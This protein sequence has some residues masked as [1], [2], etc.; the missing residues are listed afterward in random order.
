[1]KRI[2]PHV[3]PRLAAIFAVLVAWGWS[4]PGAAD[5]T[6]QTVTFRSADQDLTG[7]NPTMLTGVLMRPEGNGPFPA[8]VLLHS[9]YG[10]R[11]SDGSEVKRFYFW[12]RYL[13]D[14]GFVTLLVDSYGPRGLQRLCPLPER[15]RPIKTDRERV[16]DAYG[17]LLY[18]Q[19]RKD[20]LARSVGVMG[21]SNGGQ[22]AIWTIGD[23]HSGRPASL[24]E[25]D[26]RAALA[27][28]P[29]GCQQALRA[30]WKTNIPFLMLIGEADDWTG[31]KPCVD[32]TSSAKATGAPVEI[33]LYPGAHH[34]FD[35]PDMP[36]QVVK[37]VVLP[38]GHSP[39]V[40][41]HPQ[42]RAAAIERVRSY[43]KDRLA[44]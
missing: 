10:L 16:R 7:G 19:S 25:G 36:I 24:P 22:A 30:K 15:D 40:G 37:D 8:I 35:E 26:F 43:F 6:E 4:G 18:I 23:S 11:E 29:G 38:D 21:W 27:L 44:Q 32:L 34:A 42:A 41:T 9:C 13:R 28:Y 2:S 1:M 5:Q 33:T 17:A 12:A 3:L 31:A 20:V 39:T 14:Q